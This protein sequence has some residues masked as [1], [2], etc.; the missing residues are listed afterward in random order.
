MSFV[1]IHWTQMIIFPLKFQNAEL[2]GFKM[3]LRVVKVRMVYKQ[4][5]ILS[6]YDIVYYSSKAKVVMGGRRNSCMYSR[7]MRAELLIKI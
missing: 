2:L 1:I 6:R 3:A 4:E 5:K 7:K